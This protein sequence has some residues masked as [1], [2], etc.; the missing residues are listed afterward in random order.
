MADTIEKQKWIDGYLQWKET[1]T[2]TE[3][4]EYCKDKMYE[5]EHPVKGS[6]DPCSCDLTDRELTPYEDQAVDW[7]FTLVRSKE[8][9]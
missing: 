7:L 2:A 3:Y 9:V 1:L 6:L 5:A 4:T 8:N